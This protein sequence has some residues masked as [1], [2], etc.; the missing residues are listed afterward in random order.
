VAQVIHPCE[1]SFPGPWLLDAQAL[2]ELDSIL[3]EQWKQL[4]KHKKKEIEKAFDRAKTQLQHDDAYKAL[5]DEGKKDE[6]TKL[7][8]K[9]EKDP[10]YADDGC[11]VTLTLASK[12]RVVEASF[13]AAD[14]AP[15]CQ[16]E[17]V[18]KAEVK[19][20]CGGVKVEMVV[21]TPDKMRPLSLLTFPE[22]SPPALEA[23]IKLRKWAD[24]RRPDLLRQLQ[25]SAPFGPWFLAIAFA[26][27]FTICGMLTRPREGSSWRHD[28]KELLDKGIRPEDHGR[29][30]EMLIRK[31]LSA[32]EVQT[33]FPA[34][35]LVALVTIA[36]MALLLSVP[37]FTAFNI[38]SGK[39]SVRIQQRYDR[40]LRTL[41]PAFL[42]MG[43]LASLVSAFI[44]DFL[45]Q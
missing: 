36:L 39:R 28:A 21:P 26:G 35:L 38:A 32:Q 16:G 17:V 30:L 34:W 11:T 10:L 43:V 20:L 33:N 22:G 18:T 14:N 19:M 44:Y 2:A 45:K 31:E 40:F 12:V 7:K 25:G 15:E 23:F 5:D 6:E 27:L 4:T 8:D 24:E 9:V 29:A 3:E 42:F 41:L 13:Q 37:A 1:A